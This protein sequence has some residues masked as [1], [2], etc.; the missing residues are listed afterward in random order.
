VGRSPA[1]L[2]PVSQSPTSP[3]PQR[4]TLSLLP[5]TAGLLLSDT[6][7]VTDRVEGDIIPEPLKAERCPV[8]LSIGETAEG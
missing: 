6:V 7:G 2:S 8:S 3:E 1:H 4:T 5:E